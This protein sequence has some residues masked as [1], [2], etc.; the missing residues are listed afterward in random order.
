LAVVSL[1]TEAFGAKQV[2]FQI[3]KGFHCRKCQR[4][5]D[6]DNSYS[7]AVPAATIKT[8]FRAGGF[9]IAN[10]LS[11][12][13]INSMGVAF[14]RAIRTVRSDSAGVRS[15]AW[16]RR[17]VRFRYGIPSFRDKTLLPTKSFSASAVIEPTGSPCRP[18]STRSLGCLIAFLSTLLPPRTGLRLSIG[19]PLWPLSY[20]RSAIW[21]RASS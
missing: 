1:D 13:S 20:L 21:L 12:V 3:D 6:I 16:L 17:G 11:L 9:S 5:R 8:P 18:R 10:R 14:S 7:A 19:F 15:G 4:R 2:G